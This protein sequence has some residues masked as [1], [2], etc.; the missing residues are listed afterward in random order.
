M[1]RTEMKM[2]EKNGKAIEHSVARL[3]STKQCTKHFRPGERM[4]E[5]SNLF[6]INGE[7]LGAK[8][9]LTLC[10]SSLRFHYKKKKNKRKTVVGNCV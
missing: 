2:F 1:Q 9:R 10:P 4:D 6:S 8:T 5:R 7:K 3:A